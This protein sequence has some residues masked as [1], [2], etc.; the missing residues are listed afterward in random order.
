MS[1]PPVICVRAL[2]KQYGTVEALKGIDL[3]IGRGEIFGLLGPNGAGKT[4]T[5]EILEGLRAKSSGEVSVLGMDPERQSHALKQRIGVCL[6]DTNLPDKIKV[7]EALWL[8]ESFYEKRG[9]PGLWMQRLGL[10]EKQN[11]YYQHLSGGQKQRLALVL[12]LMH[13]PEIVFLDE[14][15]AGLDPQARREIH[16][17]IRTQREL[18]R[19]VVLT[20]HYIEEAD[21]LCDRVAIIDHGQIAALGTPSDLR[22]SA[23]PQGFVCIEITSKQ[24]FPEALPPP[25]DSSEQLT[26]VH[27]G[28]TLRILSAHPE[29]S[30][31]HHVQWLEQQGLGLAHIEFV[32]PSLE[33]VFVERTGRSLRE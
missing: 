21:K 28:R 25:A 15:T 26:L 1:A 32:R 23:S 11:A 22:S 10:S 29:K 16:S 2:K 13:E 14:P 12:A 24:P 9:S 20:T 31:I 19:T 18:G 8:F 30:V 5:V 33:D 6:Q 4:S 3:E 7:K 17:L 27:E